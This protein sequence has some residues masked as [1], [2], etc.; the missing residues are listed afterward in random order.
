M[1]VICASS[2]RMSFSIAS[3]TAALEPGIET[4]TVPRATPA[5]A[6]LTLTAS[7]FGQNDLLHRQ[8]HRG[9]RA[10]HRDNS[11]AARHASRGPTHHRR[12]TDLGIAQ[13]AKKF[14]KARQ[15][16]LKTTLHDLISA[17]AWGKPRAT[18]EQDSIRVLCLNEMRQQT[19]DIFWLI[20]D[21][22]IGADGVTH[23]RERLLHVLP[24]RVVVRR[25]GIAHR[26]DGTPDTAG[27]LLSVLLVTHD[28]C[29]SA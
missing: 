11:R 26:D 7:P 4:I 16:F 23:L 20:L 24:T 10:G 29:P 9:T 5:V 21:D 12:R 18:T 19:L 2:G 15:F 22:A 25:T 17:I 3:R 14:T 27:S 6:R 1:W 28:A 13:I 8:P